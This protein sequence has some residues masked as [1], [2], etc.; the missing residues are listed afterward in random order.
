MNITRFSKLLA[1]TSIASLS[2]L[3]G[4]EVTQ[5]EPFNVSTSYN[6][7]DKSFGNR[8]ADSLQLQ[9][10]VDTH[11]S[12]EDAM[13]AVPAFHNADSG[14]ASFGNIYS[15]RGS[16]NTPFF[17]PSSIAVYIDGV[18]GL[19]A[20]AFPEELG[21]L[22]S[23]EFL[24]GGQPS[25]IGQPA[26]A[27]AILIETVTPDP[28][29][30]RN[31]ATV[32]VG[33]DNLLFGSLFS[34]NSIGNSDAAYSLY[35][36]ESRSDGF[37]N[38]QEDPNSNIG[39]KK[40]RG[41]YLRI[42][43]P[44]VHEIES[45]LSVSWKQARDGEQAYI[46]LSNDDFTVSKTF[47]GDTHQDSITTA[48]KLFKK[49]DNSK[50]SWVSSYTDWEIGPYTTLMALSPEF[51]LDS[52]LS[53]EN[54][55]WTHELTYAASPTGS[56]NWEIG[57]YSQ[58]RDISGETS[59]G[60]YNFFVFEQSEF[61]H[62][63]EITALRANGRIKINEAL[64]TGLG[65]RLENSSQE[66][67]RNS[68]I[69]EPDSNEPTPKD[70]NSL[71]GDYF[72]SAKLSDNISSS[73]RMFLTE[74]AGGYSTYTSV[75]ELIPFDRE[76][77][78]GIELNTEWLNNEQTIGLDVS[79]YT[80]Q[81]FGCQIE[82]S[83]T[84]S[85]YY[86]VNADEVRSTG[87]EMMLWWQAN[88]DLN[89]QFSHAYT[90]TE[91]EH[92]IDPTTGVSYTGNQVPYVPRR[93]SSININYQINPII[94]LQNRWTFNSE[95]YFHEDN[96]SDLTAGDYSIGEIWLRYKKDSLGIDLGIRNLLDETYISFIN[97]GVF[98]KVNGN[99]RQASVKLS[100]DF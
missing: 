55:Q 49:F 21:T 53:Q 64:A 16:A 56:A 91:F 3:I 97:A 93:S 47:D 5:L 66:L 67:I 14:A 37:I 90:N 65:L 83:F 72:I 79:I 28:S 34:Q 96:S 84:E 45:E 30:S 41:G 35:L 54:Q 32:E 69:P 17:G 38:N 68:T 18:P 15:F 19:D 80:T 82:R 86:V 13:N 58:R 51:V 8:G 24:K 85:D 70:K 76:R 40:H 25:Q 63:T 46:P 61:S 50:V 95:V 23:L 87:G 52:D 75:E 1:T 27:G 73:V 78:R 9:L 98:Q 94:S 60:I 39:E 48:V 6:S 100:L 88:E 36:Y 44:I 43:A 10:P 11:V 81:I 89:L 7:F 12:F 33:T 31:I 26:N 20:R 29:I 74:K 92:Y 77:S 59:R 71:Q 42:T 62:T 99:P 2:P 22:K 57:A 4:D